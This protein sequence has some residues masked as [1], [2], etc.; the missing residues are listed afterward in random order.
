MGGVRECR[1]QGAPGGLLLNLGIVSLETGEYVTSLERSFKALELS[2]ETGIA[3]LQARAL[4]NIGIAYL[5]LRDLD[6]AVSHLLRAMT[7]AEEADNESQ[8]CSVMGNLGNT[9]SIQ[10]EWEEAET[11]YGKAILLAE[12]LGL[13]REQS[14]FVAGL[15]ESNFVAERYDQAL[16]LVDAHQSLIDHPPFPASAVEHLR[17][18]IAAKEGDLEGA[19]GHMEVVLRQVEA[20]G[21]R[22]P[23]QCRVCRGLGSIVLEA[24]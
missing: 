11:C 1:G 10:G 9:Y 21:E 22:G 3:I 13:D 17:G 7:K 4:G 24:L 15:A 12:R 2:V 14:Y 6:N 23:S 5:R 20:R 16:E 8:M 18:Q 19:M